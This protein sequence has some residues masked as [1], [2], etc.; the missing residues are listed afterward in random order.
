[1]RQLVVLG[2]KVRS[3]LVFRSRIQGDGLTGRSGATARCV[4][5]QHATPCMCM[6]LVGVS[7][8][9]KIHCR[10]TLPYPQR[11]AIDRGDVL[12]DLESV[13]GPT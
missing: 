6:T 12:N 1:M 13:T 8:G 9:P 2:G 4:W 10:D 3:P 11:L 7:D 5:D